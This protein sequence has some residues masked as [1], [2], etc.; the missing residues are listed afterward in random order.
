M[1]M[2]A[3]VRSNSTGVLSNSLLVPSNLASMI[4]SY[5]KDQWQHCV[6]KTNT[7]V[8]PN[9]TWLDWLQLQSTG[10]QWLCSS[11]THPNAAVLWYDWSCKG[12]TTARLLSCRPWSSSTVRTSSHTQY[13][14]LFCPRLSPPLIFCCLPWKC[15]LPYIEYVHWCLH[16]TNGSSF[17]WAPTS[18]KGQT[19]NQCCNSSCP[20]PQE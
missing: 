15:C 14:C 13:P 9:T 10:C 17:V 7:W 4:W 6:H 8:D 19:I 16:S 5:P 1:T 20:V 3:D 2:V 11:T 12:T 18:H